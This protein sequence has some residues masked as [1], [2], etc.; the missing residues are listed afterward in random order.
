M[1]LTISVIY[2]TLYSNLLNL[3]AKS[4]TCVVRGDHISNS[5]DL[6][7]SCNDE[8][9]IKWVPLIFFFLFLQ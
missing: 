6:E 2:E 1:V 4:I 8:L 7:I 3:L 9:F 5:Q